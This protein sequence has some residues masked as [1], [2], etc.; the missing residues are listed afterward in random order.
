MNTKTILSMKSITTRHP[1]L[2]ALVNEVMK[3]KMP[4]IPYQRSKF[5]IVS[6]SSI[7]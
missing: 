7:L 3:P 1:M 6:G 2:R 5:A 4:R